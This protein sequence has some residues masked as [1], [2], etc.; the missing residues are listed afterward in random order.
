MSQRFSRS[1][2]R[3]RGHGRARRSVLGVAI[4]ASL[5]LGAV[6]G[7]AVAAPAAP[8]VA[9]PAAAREAAK[10]A[11]AAPLAVLVFHGAAADQQDPVAR[12]TAT[13][14][15]LGQDNGVAVTESSDPAVF[16]AA[17][18]AGYRAVVFLSATGAVLTGDQETALQN[19]L[20]AGGGFVGIADAAKAQPDSTW[21]T[22]LIGTRPVGAL[23]TAEPVS[24]VTASAENPPN[25][26]KEKL[27]DGNP[28][29]KWLAFATTGWVAYQ[30]AAP[31][32][33][34]SYALTS[35]GDEPGRDPKD[36]TLQG[37]ADGQDWTEVDR[38]TG[39]S[40]AERGSVKRYPVTG[41]A[42][43][44]HYRLNITANNDAPLVQLADL[45]LF[46]GGET[47]AQPPA[48]NRA[49]VD[50]VDRQHPAT[51]SLPL[52]VI[53]SDRWYN[54]DPSPV[55]TV[56]T[57]AQVE[58]RHYDPGPGANGPFHPVS[59]CRDYEGG[60]SFYTGMGHTEASY[61]A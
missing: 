26:T 12:A 4:G 48:V 46:A 56:H 20:K 61:G 50:I 40:F 11:V 41:G 1:P 8:A 39:Q 42:E 24:T 29:T 45:R 49:V 44:R 18:L 60:R 6:V 28:N 36:W 58:E 13:I 53:R 35:G 27:A 25:E 9:A 10:A 30:L 22:G 32:T 2:Y 55:G 21:F 51:A 34:T 52:T 5:V 54:W 31:T 3:I 38:R 19:Y 14:K 33:V 47:P 59:W 15:E 37:S 43:Y 16:T 23:P 17:G 7:P 57:L